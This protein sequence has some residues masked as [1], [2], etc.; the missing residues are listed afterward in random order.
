M[1]HKVSTAVLVAVCAF[2]L[3]AAS[4]CENTTPS[5]QERE[6]LNAAIRDYLDALAGAYATLDARPLEEFAA[7]GEVVEVQKLLRTMVSTGDRVEAALLSVEVKEMNVFRVVNATVTLTEV[8]DVRRMDAFTGREKARNTGSIQESLIQLRLI[9]GR[10]LVTAR[11]VLQTDGAS[12]WTFPT[13]SPGS[14]AVTEP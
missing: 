10:W 14:K 6:A 13:P 8:W 4:A 7:A 1:P 9:D 5:D 2:A 12:R 11:R 3:L